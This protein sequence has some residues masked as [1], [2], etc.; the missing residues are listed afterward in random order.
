MAS[1]TEDAET[2]SRLEGRRAEQLR[3]PTMVTIMQRINPAR[4]LRYSTKL[5]CACV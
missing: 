1:S 2:P 5:I 4:Y 3:L